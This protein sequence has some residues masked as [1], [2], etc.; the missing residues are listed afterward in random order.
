MADTTTIARPIGSLYILCRINSALA[1][2]R[3]EHFETLDDMLIN[4]APVVDDNI[5]TAVFF[6]EANQTVLISLVTLPDINAVFTE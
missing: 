5:E 2:E 1:Q 6:A 4:M 3:K